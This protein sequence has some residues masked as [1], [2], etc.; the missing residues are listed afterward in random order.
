MAKKIQS[1]DEK[2]DVL[3]KQVEKVEETALSKDKK[4]WEFHLNP[5]EHK[6]N[7]LLKSVDN[8]QRDNTK[9]I[10]EEELEKPEEKATYDRSLVVNPNCSDRVSLTG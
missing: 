10:V 2:V 4:L 7:D 6:I 8:L 3:K 9:E 1:L 5:L